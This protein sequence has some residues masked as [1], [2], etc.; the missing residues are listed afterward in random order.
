MYR[1][2]EGEK[3][4]IGDGTYAFAVVMVRFVNIS[5]DCAASWVRV[6]WASIGWLDVRR[7]SE[8]ETWKLPSMRAFEVT[9]VA[10]SA[11]IDCVKGTTAHKASAKE[12]MRT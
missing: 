7:S 8:R 6:T 5:S 9:I 4:A 3:A 11:S 2:E 10:F 1:R 12:Q